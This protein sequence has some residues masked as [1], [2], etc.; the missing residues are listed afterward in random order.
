MVCPER[1]TSVK[2]SLYFELVFCAKVAGH[3]A[4]SRFDV[5]VSLPVM[6]RGY[7]GLVDFITILG[8]VLVNLSGMLTVN[9]LDIERIA[10]LIMRYVDITGEVASGLWRLYLHVFSL[11]CK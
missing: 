4:S 7:T 11:C 3:E 1:D 2:Y 10:T 9:G 6:Q 5:G 8:E